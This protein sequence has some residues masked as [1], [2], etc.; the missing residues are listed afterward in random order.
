[1]PKNQLYIFI[2]GKTIRQYGTNIYEMDGESNS[3]QKL[4]LTN[5][6][7]HENGEP[8]APWSLQLKNEVEMIKETT[9]DMRREVWELN[10]DD[11]QTP[12]EKFVPSIEDLKDE[13]IAEIVKRP[14]DGGRDYTYVLK[15]P[16]EMIKYYNIKQVPDNR[17]ARV[18]Y[19]TFRRI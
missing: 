19:T 13:Q 1:M 14:V 15:T 6:L 5:W 11:I 7:K 2:D 18:G 4:T 10:D 3:K 8:P 9:D 12:E 16:I 17:P